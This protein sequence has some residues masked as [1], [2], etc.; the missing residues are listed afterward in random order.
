MSAC[1]L[2]LVHTL[3]FLSQESEKFAHF[4]ERL[5]QLQ[6]QADIQVGIHPDIQVGIHPDIQ[7]GI[8]PDMQAEQKVGIPTSV[9]A[10]VSTDEHWKELFV[11]HY[12]QD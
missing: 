8:H 10:S 12:K 2:Q 1:F 9:L 7:V 6:R 11:G 4:R 5:S 3:S